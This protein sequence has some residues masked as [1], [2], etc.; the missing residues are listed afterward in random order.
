MR[1]ERRARLDL[2]T[3]AG[4]EH[5]PGRELAGHVG[6]ELGRELAE[7]SASIGA[8]RWAIRST[9]AASAEPPPMPP[10]IGICLPIVTW[11][12]GAS[13]P[14]D[15]NPVSA[16]ETMF[17]SSTPGHTTSSSRA[18]ASDELELVRK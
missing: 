12:R 11:T 6:A 13:Q 8:S 2:V 16:R 5:E 17:G 14:R 4:A 1:G 3:R 9:A 10:A 7:G 18:D 15:R